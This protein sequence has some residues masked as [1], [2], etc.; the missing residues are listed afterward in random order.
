M[1]T[2]KTENQ[3][4]IKLVSF[5]SD[6]SAGTELSYEQIQHDSGITMDVSGKALMRRAVKECG[7]VYKV[8][9]GY[10][11]WL[12]S[13]DNATEIVTIQ[14]TRVRHT[15]EKTLTTIKIL[16]PKY[17]NQLPKQEQQLMDLREGFVNM[18][19]AQDQGHKVYL[20][21]RKELPGHEGEIPYG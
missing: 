12:D 17:Y 21:K 4:L 7:R 14:T 10:G 2:H 11:I 5:F 8:K 3:D 1:K 20:P 18:A 15:V 6:Q 9:P 19:L 16:K 13:K